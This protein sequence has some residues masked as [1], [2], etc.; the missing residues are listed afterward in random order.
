MTN[1]AIIKA[2]HVSK[3]FLIPMGGAAKRVFELAGGEYRVLNNVA[4][5]V[6]FRLGLFTGG[7][8]TFCPRMK[9]LWLII[10]L[11]PRPMSKF[12]R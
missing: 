4:N 1:A 8:I 7:A 9:K 5:D 6:L 11:L 2:A 10:A 12:I 3:R